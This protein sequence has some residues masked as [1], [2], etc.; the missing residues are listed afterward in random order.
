M[1]VVIVISPSDSFNSK[2][3]RSTV[4]SSDICHLADPGP[5]PDL[6][7]RNC[8]HQAVFVGLSLRSNGDHPNSARRVV[9][10]PSHTV[11]LI[12]LLLDF[13]FAVFITVPWWIGFISV[14][15]HYLA[16]SY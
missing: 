6:L 16:R 5:S 4:L 7:L 9:S 11:A 1:P 14:T 13:D 15:W 10:C 2:V 12:K 8:P 3:T